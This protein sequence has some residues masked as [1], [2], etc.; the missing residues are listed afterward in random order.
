MR[1]FRA[2]DPDDAGTNPG[3]LPVMSARTAWML[4]VLAFIA[5]ADPARGQEICPGD[6]YDGANQLALSWDDCW[7]PGSVATSFKSFNCS[8][9]PTTNVTGQLHFQ[10]RTP[11]VVHSTIAAVAIVRLGIPS[12][13]PLPAFYHY[14]TTGCAGSGAVRGIALSA[15][16]PPVRCV[17]NDKV[18]YTPYCGGPP[19]DASAYQCAALYLGY[20]P[21]APCPGLGM[22]VLSIM[23]TVG[24]TLEPEAFYWLGQLEF[25]NRLRGVCAGC[26]TPLLIHWQSLAIESDDGQGTL[27]FTGPDSPQGP[28]RAALSRG[29][30]SGV[31]PGC[32]VSTRSSTWGHIKALY[33]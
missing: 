16:P 32:T 18:A 2:D 1:R 8:P 7:Y 21:D 10:F 31:H 13:E 6:G 23:R 14:E 29:I 33:R 26:V 5:A 11:F 12:A 3:A 17:E 19:E 28:D 22:L 24:R 30:P 4:A 27:C 9:S 25:N 15:Y 20:L